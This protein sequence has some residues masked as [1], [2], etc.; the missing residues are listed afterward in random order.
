MKL[1]IVDLSLYAKQIAGQ[2][3]GASDIYEDDENEETSK[4]FQIFRNLTEL[5]YSIP[6]SLVEFLFE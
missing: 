3:Y 4:E 1:M 2:P 6:I 5:N